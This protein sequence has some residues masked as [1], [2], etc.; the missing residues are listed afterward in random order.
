MAVSSSPEKKKSPPSSSETGEF[1]DVIK[2]FLLFAAMAV[3]LVPRS[4]AAPLLTRSH[5]V[6]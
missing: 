4:T 5:R 2:V 3:T 1:N 6:E